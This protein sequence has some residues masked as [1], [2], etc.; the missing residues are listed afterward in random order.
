MSVTLS[1]SLPADDRNGLGSIA[2]ALIE[3]EPEKTHV[4]V[5]LVDCVE[6]KT[7]KASGD[8]IPRIRIKAVE[9][10]HGDGG[11]AANLSRILTAAYE[12][13]TGK[14]ALPLYEDDE[15]DDIEVVPYDDYEAEE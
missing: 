10:F 1:G 8:T 5:A 9:A 6:L 12:Q 7:K 14:V 2:K 11:S 4:I 3:D 15:I 13:R